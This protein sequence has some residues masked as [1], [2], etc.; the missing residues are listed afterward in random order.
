MKGKDSK[1]AKF[2]KIVYFDEDA[3]Q[4]YV[5]VANGGRFDWSTEENEERIAK[6]VAEIEAE[7][8]SDF[9]ILNYIKATVQGKMNAGA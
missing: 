5:D 2:L 3:A 6:F 7:A 4:D 1:E 9:N 8:K